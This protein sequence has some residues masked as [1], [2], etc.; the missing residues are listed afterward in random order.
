MMEDSEMTEKSLAD[1]YSVSPNHEVYNILKDQGDLAGDHV[2]NLK[3]NIKRREFNFQ[4]KKMI[5]R[6]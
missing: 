3:R 2:R 6:N 1:L 5:F 4:K